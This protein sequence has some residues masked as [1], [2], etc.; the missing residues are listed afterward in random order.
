M[1]DENSPALGKES[2]KNKGKG[3]GVGK[4]FVYLMNWGKKKPGR[5]NQSGEKEKKRRQ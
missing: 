5:L 3:F 4:S 1:I 2:R